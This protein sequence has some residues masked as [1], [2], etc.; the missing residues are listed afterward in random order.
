[1]HLTYTLRHPADVTRHDLI[2][3]FNE[4]AIAD[5]HVVHDL[6]NLLF[7]RRCLQTVVHDGVDSVQL[8]TKEFV[9]LR[10]RNQN[11]SRLRF[12]TAADV[13]LD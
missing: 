1:M 8:H 9:T 12:H 4:Q 13:L 2:P 10:L 7:Y 3:V 5:A 6:G 11:L